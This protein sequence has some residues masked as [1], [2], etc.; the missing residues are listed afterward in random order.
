[1]AEFRMDLGMTLSIFSSVRKAWL[2]ASPL[3]A[4]ML[5]G[6]SPR[7]ETSKGEARESM[8]SFATHHLQRPNDSVLYA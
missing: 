5:N 1:M 7:G 4:A 8:R 6:D 2:E 3:V